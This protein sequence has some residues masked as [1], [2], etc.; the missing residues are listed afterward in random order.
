LPGLNIVVG[1]PSACSIAEPQRLKTASYLYQSR[2]CRAQKRRQA[3]P[4]WRMVGLT[5]LPSLM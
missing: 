3:W 2:R 5:R 4:S 1:V